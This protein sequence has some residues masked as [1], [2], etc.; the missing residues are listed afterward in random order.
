[1]IA[2]LHGFTWIVVVVLLSGCATM[3]NPGSQTVPVASTP[4]GATVFI[5]GEPMGTTPLTLTLNNQAPVT[6]TLRLP[7]GRERTVELERR[8]D[9][10]SFTVS[11]VPAAV[12]G[13]VV[14]G[15]MLFSSP[16]STSGISA[17]S[18]PPGWL[19]TGFFQFVG[20]V[21]G[22]GVS[23]VSFGVDAATGSWFRLLPGEVLVVF[24][25]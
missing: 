3:Y 16:V 5:D 23:V 9:D 11:L 12:V 14:V 25:D 7:D 4:T 13:G 8:F 1:M 15:G 18:S 24:D 10:T 20:V 22:A 6:L 17:S 19:V 2:R 21:A